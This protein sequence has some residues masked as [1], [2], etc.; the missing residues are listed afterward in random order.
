MKKQALT[1]LPAIGVLVLLGVFLQYKAMLVPY[2]KPKLPN[3]TY[4]T[5]ILGG[6]GINTPTMATKAHSDDVQVVFKY[7]QVPAENSVLGQKLKQLHMS[8]I[9]GYLSSELFYYECHRTKTIKPPPPQKTP[10]CKT[11]DKP[12]LNSENALLAD[13]TDHLRQVQNNQLVVGYWVLDDW[14]SWDA[15]SAQPILIKIHALIQKYTPKHPAICGF[16][17]LLDANHS[18]DWSDWLADN[19]SPDGCDAVGLYVY[20]RELLNTSPSIADTYDWSMSSLLPVLFN[21]LQ[22]R[23]W[24][25]AQEPLIGIGQAFGGVDAN[26]RRYSFT[27]TAKDIET[28]ALSFCQQGAIG[29]SFYAWDDSGFSSASHT[30]MN[31]PQIELGIRNGISACKHYWST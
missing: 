2:P 19:F 22:R 5:H 7:E 14:A 26:T 24:N 15:G 17:A 3:W 10:F 16:G 21:S 31:S 28:Q 4:K 29:V 23:G 25:I 27:P 13:V 30:P 20:T 1:L 11:D 6:F 8:V 18:F 9:D 12:N